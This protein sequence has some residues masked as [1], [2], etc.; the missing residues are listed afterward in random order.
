VQRV[1]A[2]CLELDPDRCTRSSGTRHDLL[3]AALVDAGPQRDASEPEP[4]GP[5]PRP[6]ENKDDAEDTRTYC[7]FALDQYAGLR[8]PIA[9]DIATAA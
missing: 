1:V 3:A 8:H 4:G 7:L 2:Q 9:H 6:G 5:P